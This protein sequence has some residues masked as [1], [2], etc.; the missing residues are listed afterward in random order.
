MTRPRR[1]LL[2]PKALFIEA[3]LSSTAT[4]GN[5]IEELVAV[6]DGPDGR[7][8]IREWVHKTVQEPEYS[9]R[10]SI[11]VPFTGHSAEHQWFFD[12]RNGEHRYVPGEHR[13]SVVDTTSLTRASATNGVLFSLTFHLTQGQIAAAFRTDDKGKL[14]GHLELDYDV[15]AGTYSVVPWPDSPPEEPARDCL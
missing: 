14:G 15:F 2:F 9:E 6:P 4:Q 5:I 11:F 3:F 10:T 12:K 7:L 13:L 1:I 8:T